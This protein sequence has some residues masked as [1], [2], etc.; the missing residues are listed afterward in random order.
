MS[1]AFRHAAVGLAVV[2]PDGGVRDANP[3]FCCFLAGEREPLLR[4]CLRDLVHPDDREAHSAWFGRLLGGEVSS[5]E[6]DERYLRLDGAV[7]WGRTTMTA[8]PDGAG[9]VGQVVCVVDPSESDPAPRGR[10]G[11]GAASTATSGRRRV[12]ASWRSSATS[13]GHR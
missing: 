12:S 6:R 3:A 9:G 5:Y 7:A 13:S 2:A 11:P 4:Q 1:V 8:V 10:C